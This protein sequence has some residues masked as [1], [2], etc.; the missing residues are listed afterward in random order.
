ML[1]KMMVISSKGRA[2]NW[3]DDVDEARPEDILRTKGENVRVE[4]ETKKEGWQVH[5]RQV[6]RLRAI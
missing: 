1:A 5:D 2:L 3:H 6:K 4:G